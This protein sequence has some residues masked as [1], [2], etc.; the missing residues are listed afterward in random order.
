MM[1]PAG[2]SGTQRCLSLVDNG[3]NAPFAQVYIFLLGKQM[4][5]QVQSSPKDMIM[6]KSEI[7]QRQ[8]ER[9]HGQRYAMV[10]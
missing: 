10:H 6:I 5:A 8:S 9:L 2:I 1:V 7:E 3:R 4:G